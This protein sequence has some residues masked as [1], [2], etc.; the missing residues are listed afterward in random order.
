MGG[1]AMIT[2]TFFAVGRLPE[3]PF[4][5]EH[6]TVLHLDLS[7]NLLSGLLARYLF[8]IPESTQRGI[9]NMIAQDRCQGCSHRRYCLST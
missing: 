4:D 3:R 2:I 7:G 9:G 6:P 8:R 1:F 5:L